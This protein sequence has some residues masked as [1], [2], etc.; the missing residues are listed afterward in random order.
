VTGVAV[1]QDKDLTL[2]DAISPPPRQARLSRRQENPTL[3]VIKSV[4]INR[5]RQ[6]VYEFLA[7]S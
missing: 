7:R 1:A 3:H 6:E 4:T 2:H 5:P